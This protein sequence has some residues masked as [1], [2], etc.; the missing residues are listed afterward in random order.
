LFVNEYIGQLCV[1]VC[2]QVHTHVHEHMW[3]EEVSIGL[4]F[5]ATSDLF[6]IQ[7]LSELEFIECSTLDN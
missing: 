7:S 4:H 3:S 2:A 1:G 6:D 5:Q